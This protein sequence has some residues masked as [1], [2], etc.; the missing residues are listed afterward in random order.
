MLILYICLTAAAAALL[1][2]SW[3]W[4]KK[5]KDTSALTSEAE[6]TVIKILTQKTAN[7][8]GEKTNL[9]DIRVSY[10]VDGRKYKASR[11]VVGEES[12]FQEGQSVTVLYDADK[13]R[14]S[15]VKGDEH[16]ERTWQIYPIA[17]LLL[18]I[19]M[20]TILIITLPYTLGF[21]SEGKKLFDACFKAFFCLMCLTFIL[22]YRH[23]KEYKKERETSK[24]KVNGN[25]AFAVVFML[26]AAFDVVWYILERFVF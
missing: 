1:L 2:Y 4:Y 6:G 13:P 12:G 18:F 16:P 17:A 26:K 7:E 8:A 14:H 3:S 23:T 19:A 15:M 9:H 25:I 10:E 22:F 24:K 21:T 11:K 5:M 20:L